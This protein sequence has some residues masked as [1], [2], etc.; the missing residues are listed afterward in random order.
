MIAGGFGFRNSIDQI[1]N[2]MLFDKS[3]F[4]F[5]FAWFGSI[6]AS[7]SYETFTVGLTG[8]EA[9]E[10]ITIFEKSKDI[11][12]NITLA[13]KVTTAN[14]ADN[15]TFWTSADGKDYE[16]YTAATSVKYGDT[17]YVKFQ[18]TNGYVYTA[19]ATEAGTAHVDGTVVDAKGR[20]EVAAEKDEDGRT[21]YVGY[22]TV[23][24]VYEASTITLTAVAKDASTVTLDAVSGDGAAKSI[25][26]S[27]DN[28]ANYVAG[29]SFTAAVGDTTIVKFVGADDYN[30]TVTV[31]GNDALVNGKNTALIEK[32]GGEYKFTVTGVSADTTITITP[33]LKGYTFV[34]VD[35]EDAGFTPLLTFKVTSLKDDKDKNI[36]LAAA[37]TKAI[38]DQGIT[39]A[40]RKTG[41]YFDSKY[42]NKDTEVAADAA[43]HDWTI[44][45][46]APTGATTTLVVHYSPDVYTIEY[47]DSE[48]KDSDGNIDFA[49][50]GTAVATQSETYGNKKPSNKAGAIDAVRT[51]Y[52][53]HEASTGYKFA[54]A[55]RIYEAE[56]YDAKGNKIADLT[57]VK[58]PKV[59]YVSRGVVDDLAVFSSDLST[60]HGGSVYVV[61]VYEDAS[62]TVNFAVGNAW[63]DFAKGS[64]SSMTIKA[65]EMDKALPE[66]MFS[67]VGYD[68]AG[69]A[70]SATDSGADVSTYG[71]VFL[72]KS[73]A[74][75]VTLYA[76]FALHPYT[77]TYH[78]LQSAT[79]DTE[80]YTYGTSHD[81]T[82]PA[83]MSG[84]AFDG[85][86]YDAE[87]KKAVSYNTSTGKYY[88][89]ATSTGD[90]NVY[91]KYVASDITIIYDPNYSDAT[92]KKVEQKVKNN[93]K[94]TLTKNSF[95]R[96]NYEFAGWALNTDGAVTY[97]DQADVAFT[98]AQA[99]DGKVSLFAVWAASGTE[100]TVT[101]DLNG[102]KATATDGAI[103]GWTKADSTYSA[104]YTYGTATTYP[105]L[106][107]ADDIKLDNYELA[108][109]TLVGSGEAVT[110]ISGMKGN[111]T[112]KAKWAGKTF[113]VTYDSNSSKLSKNTKVSGKMNA[114]NV[115]Y[116]DTWAPL[117][118]A[119]TANGYTFQGWAK[120]ADS[121]TAIS[122]APSA[123]EYTEDQ[124]LYAIWKAESEVLYLYSAYGKID[125]TSYKLGTH[126]VASSGLDVFSYAF[127][128]VT[129][130]KVA[131]PTKD[132]M[133]PDANGL[134]FK[135]WY[136]SA[137]DAYGNPT[138][139][140]GSKKASQVAIGDDTV[141]VAKWV[142]NY[143]VTFHNG[144]DEVSQKIKLDK[145]TSLK[146]NKFKESGYIF[147]GWDIDGDGVVDFKNK[148]KV[149]NTILNTALGGEPELLDYD[150]YAVFVPTEKTYNL[151]VLDESG[152]VLETTTFN[153]K[154]GLAT[155]KVTALGKSL[156]SNFNYFVD[157]VT[158]KKVSKIKAKTA[159]DQTFILVE[160]AKVVKTTLV[161]DKNAPSGV[162]VTGSV[163]KKTVKSTAEIVKN[164]G[165]FKAKGLTVDYFTDKATN[166]RYYVTPNGSMY[167]NAGITHDGA[168]ITDTY[169][170]GKV[171]LT[172][173]WTNEEP[174]VYY[175][176]YNLGAAD[177]N[178][179]IDYAY[180]TL[181][182]QANVNGCKVFR[183]VWL[184]FDDAYVLP[185]PTR[186][187]YKF[188]GWTEQNASGSYVKTTAA[189]T[190]ATTRNLVATWT[191][192]E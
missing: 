181:T 63:S 12:G 142:G 77:I 104:K 127:D 118:S 108:G 22:F 177:A 106:P 59:K 25:S 82:D 99:T 81:L 76:T 184:L 111:F 70:L 178:L 165:K 1:L 72:T 107:T 33:A 113:K 10:T 27:K 191:P 129:T 154:K 40:P 2:I 145:S 192:I 36:T 54:K 7:G 9:S 158:G 74:S 101:L 44:D 42:Y 85:W 78:D 29:T 141:Y 105:T 167:L 187:G 109:W 98:S 16:A 152:S 151:T 48:Q 159:G 32:T 28:G 133:D 155:K 51:A 114:V 14:D 90:I 75:S 67:A 3:V 156:S 190:S 144:T 174:T 49:N 93:I 31:D 84:F 19:K 170:G 91:A 172:A 148:A 21:I 13:G 168:H 169:V 95:T 188:A 138:Y 8:V 66:S 125:E 46:L 143:T 131:L 128:D 119:F 20:M 149:T 171:T 61:P 139:K 87:Y 166:L 11:T 15:I 121:T 186:A 35:D 153:Y 135:G 124:T 5:F 161:F 71:D 62:Y 185:T 80:T 123:W 58:S 130:K 157:S 147:T 115:K 38:N 146:A 173:H 112:L 23:T 47:F 150:L 116:G 164:V 132:Q 64:N 83:A 41:Y 103:T 56:Y 137:V 110:S 45:A 68:F 53:A 26:Y 136:K 43:N 79:P 162:K 4:I 189:I 102:G 94:A 183:D 39:F 89:P 134:T 88:I 55:W 17:L 57:D 122:M 34:I 126:T 6:T 52:A 120:T 30:Y 18:G 24:N 86:Y 96:D 37:A 163:S 117:D 50:A 65:S 69:W 92:A 175:Y 182:A 60:T 180:S 160:K 140:P 73:F 100:Y 176:Y 179:N 97:L